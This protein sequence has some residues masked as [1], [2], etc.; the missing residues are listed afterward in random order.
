MSIRSLALFNGGPLRGGGRLARNRHRHHAGPQRHSRHDEE[1]GLSTGHHWGPRSGHQ[2][3]LFHGHGQTEWAHDSSIS[4]LPCH[5]H[6][7]GGAP[8][9]QRPDPANRADQHTLLRCAM[10]PTSSM[11]S[12]PPPVSRTGMRPWH[13]HWR[14]RTSVAGSSQGGRAR[15]LGMST[16]ASGTLNRRTPGRS[17]L[18]ENRTCFSR[19]P[20]RMPFVAPTCTKASRTSLT[21][22]LER[23]LRGSGSSHHLAKAACT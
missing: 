16:G 3:G 13:W 9:Q 8:G 18:W 5:R 12:A 23:R 4:A 10:F 22:Q 6:D 19:R 20:I 7:S 2:W 21:M 15:S 14:C 11:P 1:W 17:D